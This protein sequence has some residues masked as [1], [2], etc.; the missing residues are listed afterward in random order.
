M[1]D[2]RWRGSLEAGYTATGGRRRVSVIAATEAE[3]KRRLQAKRK[4][5]DMED[6]LTSTRL[7]VKGWADEWLPEYTRRVRPGTAGTDTSIVRKWI[8]PAI[9]H[10]RLD[11]LTPADARKVTTAIRSAGRSSTTQGYAIAVLKR[12]LKAAIQDGHRVPPPILGVSRPADAVHDRDAI[13]VKQAARLLQAADQAQGGVRWWLAL[14]EGLRQAEALGLTWDAVELEA[15]TVEVEW[16]L[17]ALT[18][19]DRAADRFR[20][21]D[22]YETRRLAGAFHLVRP[23]SRAG[24]RVVPL[25][26]PVVERL[27]AWREV[28]PVSPHGLVFPRAVRSTRLG[29]GAPRAAT[30]DRDE[31]RALQEGAGVQHPSGRRYVVHEAR[32]TTATFL[33]AAGVDPGVVTM[34]MG[35]SSIATTRGYQH[36]DL[37]Q[38]RLGLGRAM[39]GLLAA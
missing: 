36:V 16:Q 15:A 35:H 25:L 14:T 34:I 5:L 17:Q 6:G 13:P 1:K 3:C 33:L 28:A 22:G 2:G 29:P 4:E 9:G 24:F 11:Q 8:I 19:A 18:Y 39:A 38:A 30:A 37:A 7:T 31:W 21:P 20:V 26:D 10:R 23:K 32:H 27:K 12:M